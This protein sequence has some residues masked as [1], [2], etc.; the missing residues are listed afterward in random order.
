MTT[1]LA[2]G[3]GV[4]AAAFFVS[5]RPSPSKNLKAN[6]IKKGTSRLSRF[7]QISR[8]CSRCSSVR[9]SVLQRGV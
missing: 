6:K 2:V 4:A 9:K 8:R 7:P 5:A 3:M 1:V